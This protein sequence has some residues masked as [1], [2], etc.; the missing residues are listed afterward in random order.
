MMAANY[1]PPDNQDNSWLGPMFITVIVVVLA[2]VVGL[3]L[4]AS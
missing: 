2:I 1:R 4:L 3:K